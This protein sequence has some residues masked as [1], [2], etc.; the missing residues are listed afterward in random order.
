MLFFCTIFTFNIIECIR[1]RKIC[2]TEVHSDAK[3]QHFAGPN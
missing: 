1:N 2:R 3:S